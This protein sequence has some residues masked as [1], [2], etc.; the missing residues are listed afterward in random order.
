M[1]IIP[2]Y[3]ENPNIVENTLKSLIKQNV[4]MIIGIGLEERET[5]SNTK[6]DDIIKQYENHFIKI[7]KT[8][9]PMNLKN[10]IPGK[11]SNCN[12]NAQQ[13]VKFYEENHINLRCLYKHV[14]ITV[15]DCDSIWINDYFLYL[16]YLCEQNNMKNFNYIAY[17]PNITNFQD[18]SLNHILSNWVSVLRSIGT[19]GH[20][21]FLGYVRA[22]VS[23]YHI[24]LELLKR[25]DFWDSDLVQEDIH[26]H[27][28]LAILDEK[29]FVVKHTFLP[30]DNQIP[31]DINSFVGS[32]Q[33]LW[34]QTSRWNL[35][36]YE[37]YYL[38]Y[39]LLLNIFGIKRY[40]NFRTNTSKIF[41]Q[42]I[43]NYENLFFF[44]MCP[45]S[46]NIFW[47]FYL[48]IWNEHYLNSIVYH[49]LNN[50]QP[51]FI[52]IHLFLGILYAAF[53][54]YAS[55]EHI[56]DRPYNWIKFTIFLLGFIPLPSLFFIC[57]AINLTNAWIQTL[58]SNQTHSESAPK[59]LF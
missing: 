6:Y 42:I 29:H 45:I 2:I 20:F 16:N 48:H 13:L 9:H 17:V 39:E 53:I 5:D 22:F 8:I 1:V 21:Y 31:T 41:V 36:I 46:N 25:I 38:F 56:K 24:P 47:F 23:E 10:E 14:M 12:Y 49:L 32:F 27:N 19:H 59:V 7:I 57:Q 37:L 58:K 3:K 43:N 40:G 52:I 55:F 33:I 35:F 54:W 18:F 4:P 51:W 44:G 26:M 11:A 34:N 28:K 50:I 30:C 15:C